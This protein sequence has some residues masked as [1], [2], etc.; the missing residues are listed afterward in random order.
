[1][2]AVHTLCW[3]GLRPDTLFHEASARFPRKYLDHMQKERLHRDGI[4]SK[5]TLIEMVHSQIEM[6][7]RRRK[8]GKLSNLIK[9]KIY[10]N[11]FKMFGPRDKITE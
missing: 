11:T 2:S 3:T 7:N 8:K 10:C 6:K 4:R 1:M 5:S 9:I